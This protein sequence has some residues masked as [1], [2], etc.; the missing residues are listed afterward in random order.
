MK[1]IVMFAI[2][3][4]FN[5]YC[6]E[7]EYSEECIN[8]CA[9]LLQEDCQKIKLYI[10]RLL[11]LPENISD[12]SEFEQF[13]T[14]LINGNYNELVRFFL[15]KEQK[16]ER[17]LDLLGLC[18]KIALK[19][20]ELPSIDFLISCGARIEWHNYNSIISSI[21]AGNRE[22]VHYFLANNTTIPQ[23]K[24]NWFL[25]EA[26]LILDSDIANMLIAYGA[27]IEVNT[28]SLSYAVYNNDV[29]L[30]TRLLQHGVLMGNRHEEL[31]ARAGAYG[32]FELYKLLTLADFK[33]F[34]VSCY[35]E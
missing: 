1:K 32:S 20:N 29:A 23:D 6:S 18:L 7:T 25:S 5:I 13:Y 12:T 30:A 10:H 17:K 21:R 4:S 33:N 26:M 14:V 2:I 31:I 15:K 34:K 16:I 27:Q 22:M 3:L 9:K 19:R 35:L 24:L 8:I 11:Y 28:L